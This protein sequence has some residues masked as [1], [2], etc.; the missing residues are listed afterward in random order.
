MA[1]STILLPKTIL[2]DRLI[3]ANRLDTSRLVI[4]DSAIRQSYKGLP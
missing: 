1:Y 4:T 2:Q 3:I